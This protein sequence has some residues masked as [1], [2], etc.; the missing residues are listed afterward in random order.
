M[1][2]VTL[3]VGFR[4][5]SLGANTWNLLGSMILIGGIVLC[6]GPEVIWGRYWRGTSLDARLDVPTNQH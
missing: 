4:V 1:A 6:F 2:V 3:M 5:F